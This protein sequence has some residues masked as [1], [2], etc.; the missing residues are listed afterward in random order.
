M[1]R[2]DGET[3]RLALGDNL[4]YES[5]SFQALLDSQSLELIEASAG[6]AC[7]EAQELD[8]EP[9]ISMYQVARSLARSMPQIPWASVPDT[10]TAETR[11]AHPGYEE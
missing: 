3:H 8:L 10:L 11:V 6:E 5:P 9:C 4:R 2:F 7:A 1:K